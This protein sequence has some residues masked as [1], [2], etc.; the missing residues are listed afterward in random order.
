M[1]AKMYN[2]IVN[3]GDLSKGNKGYIT[4]HKISSIE[5]FKVFLSGKYPSWKF[6][7]IYNHIT[8]EKIEVIKR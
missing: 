7:T 1:N 2:A 5:R 3:V 6:A 8:K 4:Y